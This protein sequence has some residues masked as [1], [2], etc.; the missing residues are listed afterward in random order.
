[1]STQFFFQFPDEHF[2]VMF[3]TSEL[4]FIQETLVSSLCL[5]VGVDCIQQQPGVHG[6]IVQDVRPVLLTPGGCLQ[7][8]L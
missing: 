1:M 2:V 5:F 6:L 3:D 8:I 4:V 7:E